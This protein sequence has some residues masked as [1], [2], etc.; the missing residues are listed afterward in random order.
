MDGFALVNLIGGVLVVTSAIITIVKSPKKAAVGYIIQSLFLVGI[1]LVMASTTGNTSLYLWS[2]S[3]FITKV[4]IVPIIILVL[5]KKLGPDFAVVEADHSRFKILALIAIEI[6]LCFVV[7]WN[8]DISLIENVKP[9]FAISLAHFF[10]GLTCI[11]TQNNIVKQIFGYCLMENGAH[12]SLAILA[13]G[14]PELVEIGIATDAIFAVLIM[15]FVV[16]KVS[17]TV[18]SVNARDLMDLKG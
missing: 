13:P 6:A 17:R 16:Y 15:A 8:L 4:I 7:V 9:L 5:I 18:K 10:V 3:A 2:V 14:A 11:T 1:L 12:I